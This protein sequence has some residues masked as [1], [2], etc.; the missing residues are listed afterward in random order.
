MGNVSARFFASIN[1]EN[2]KKI[3]LT[4]LE[5][6]KVDEVWHYTLLKEKPWNFEDYLDFSDALMSIPYA[7]KVSYAYTKITAY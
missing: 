2:D 6:K 7:Y 4:F 1:Y 3:G 5:W